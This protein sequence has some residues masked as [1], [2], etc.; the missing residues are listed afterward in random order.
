MAETGALEGIGLS[1]RYG[2]RHAVQGVDVFVR[3]GEVHG[4]L[5]P[6]GAGK[7]TLLRMLLGLV[8]PD[9]GTIRMLG[10]AGGAP[11]CA[12]PDGVAGFVD[13]PRF[14]PY[15]SG[16]RNLV[17]LARLDGRA[18]RRVVDERVSAALAQVGLDRDAGVKVAG[19]SAGMR[20]RLGLAAALLRG[21][22]VLL[23]DEPTSS[24]DPAGARDLATHVHRLAADG[25]AVLLS[26]HDMAE[27][28]ELCASVTILHHGRVAFS[29]AIDDLRQRAPSALHR[30]RTSDDARAIE[31]GAA[32]A[33]VALAVATDAAGIDVEAGEDALDAYVIALG[34]AG[35]AVRGLETRERSLESL[36]LKLTADASTAAPAAPSAGEPPEPRRRG[37]VGFSFS[38]RAALSVTAIEHGKLRSQF[39]TWATLGVCLLGPVA[40]AAAMRL[41]S[42]VPEDTLFGRFAKASGFAVPLVIL[43]FAALWAFP[44]LAS[45]VGGDLFSAEDRHGTWPALLTRSRTRNELFAGKVLAALAFSLVAVLALAISS[46]A[47]GVLIIGRQPLLSLSGTLL[48]PE[49]S[50]V[51]TMSAWASVLPPVFGFTTLALLFSA[52]TRNGA[53][54]IGLPVLLG[55]A[56]QLASYVNGPMVLRRA[57][58]TSPLEAWHGFFTEHPFYGPLTQGAVTSGVYFLGS[59]V[60]AYL[61]FHRRD[62]GS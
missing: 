55:F 48:A 19:Y 50:L 62:V 33:G 13:T 14:Y 7:T 25:V 57:L 11:G 56:M 1:K 47:A 41:Q 3:A 5:G 12:L 10:L 24:L 32:R 53:A 17:L 22:R 37:P 58:L 45:I 23:L 16:R 49:R 34:Q 15:L 9:A 2:E 52:A 4:L 39:K 35:I 28:E 6:N 36:F 61:I 18:P 20:Q 44:V 40:F 27:V 46:T 42:S 31:L 38:L 59:L 51:L 21:P 43:G 8:Q 60:A 30:L 29:G 54:G 26:S